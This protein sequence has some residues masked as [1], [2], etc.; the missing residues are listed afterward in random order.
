M[1]CLKDAST[2]NFLKFSIFFLKLYIHN[3]INPKYS[4]EYEFKNCSGQ[5]TSLIE[6]RFVCPKMLGQGH[7]RNPGIQFCFVL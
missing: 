6:L 7:H 5:F 2:Q 1:I 4:S 3:I